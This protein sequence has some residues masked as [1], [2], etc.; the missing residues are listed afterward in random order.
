MF[1]LFAD[2]QHCIPTNLI[3]VVI[4]VTF[5]KLTTRKTPERGQLNFEHSNYLDPL[6][7]LLTLNML[8]YALVIKENVLLLIVEVAMVFDN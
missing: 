7:L 4:R 5:F 3:K 2:R 1:L 8:P 6:Y